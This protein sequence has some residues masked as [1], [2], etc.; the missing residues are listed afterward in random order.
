MDVDYILLVALKN[1]AA[2][3]SHPTEETFNKFICLL[4]YIASHPDATVIYADTAICLHAHSADFYLSVPNARSRTGGIFLLSIIST[5]DPPP[6]K[7]PANGPIHVI[8]NIIKIVMISAVEVEIGAGYMTAQEEFSIRTCLEEMEHPQPTTPIQV[9]K[10][11]SVGFENRTIKQKRSK[12]IDKRFYLLQDRCN[13][14]QFIIY[15]APGSN[16]IGDY[17]TKNH[18]SGSPQENVTYNNTY[19]AFCQQFN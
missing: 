12:E 16:N 4:N 15:W 14:G 18:P 19:T 2:M 5:K 7:C 9:N 13:Q 1:L 10:T 8:C 3:Q 6:D 11:T 17:H